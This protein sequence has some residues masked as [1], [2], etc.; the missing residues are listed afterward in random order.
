MTYLNGE[1]RWISEVTPVPSPLRES[2][3]G[4]TGGGKG[5]DD[6]AGEQGTSEW[7][8][9]EVLARSAR[10]VPVLRGEGLG[11]ARS[12]GIAHL[13]GSGVPGAGERTRGEA[14]SSFRVGN[15]KRL[16]RFLFMLCWR[17]S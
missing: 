6:L 3:L 5:R 17:M 4:T 10:G 14:S 16:T 2:R 12:L 1:A 13:A 8:T 9:A 7:R 11:L 15:A